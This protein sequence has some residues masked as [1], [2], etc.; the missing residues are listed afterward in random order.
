MEF[1]S[2]KLPDA[3]T[4][5]RANGKDIYLVGTAHVSKESVEDVRTTI[6]AIQPDTV[7]VE[8]CEPRYKAMVSQDNWRRMDIFKVIKEKKTLFVLAQL[9]L[10][11]FYR[12]IGD[13]LGVQP[14]AEMMEG[15]KQAELL[16]ARLV[17]ADRNVE[18]TLKRVW[19]YLGFIS[20][21]KML[22]QLV[23]SIFVSDA[24]DEKTIEE[25]KQQDQMEGM[26]ASLAASFPQVKK[27]LID[28]RDI[29]LAQRIRNAPGNTV[30]GVVGAGHVPGILEHIQEDEDLAPLEELPPKGHTGTIIKWTIPLLILLI[31]VLGF[32]KGGAEHSMESVY[33][34]FLVNGFF[35]AAGTALAL[36]NPLTIAATFVAAPL[37]S[38]NPMIAAGWVAG[39]VQAWVKKPTVADLEDIPRAIGSIKGFWKNPVCRILLVVVLANLGSTLGTFVAGSWITAR[40]F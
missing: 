20:K 16:G 34:W 11:S 12:K 18:I 25:I 32:F 38:M 14:G 33:I 26:M 24:I 1:S 7:C 3:C 10:T 15:I 27:R 31:L 8:L 36:A 28:E 40:I 29:Y 5:V 35:S 4:H 13:K 22:F 17:C 9:M 23:G 39:L 6:G 2:P 37:T 21:M 19:G 30:V